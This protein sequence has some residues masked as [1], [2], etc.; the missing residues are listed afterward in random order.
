MVKAGGLNSLGAVATRETPAC[1]LVCIHIRLCMALIQAR[2][3]GKDAGNS[4]RVG[5]SVFCATTYHY[6]TFVRVYWLQTG[7]NSNT[8]FP[9]QISHIQTDKS[10]RI[11]S[12]QSQSPEGAYECGRPTWSGTGPCPYPTQS[13]CLYLAS[14]Y[15]K[16]L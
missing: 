9:Y 15:K 7:Y 2:L 14:E 3:V 5:P 12:V 11:M 1:R 4:T 10:W 6:N 8:R 13:T 16:I